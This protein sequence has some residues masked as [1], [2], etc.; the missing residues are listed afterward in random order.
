MKELPLLKI[1]A[2]LED[3]LW[4]DPWVEQAKKTVNSVICFPWLRDVLHGVPLGHPF[5]PVAVQI[6]LGAW[7][8]A[9]VLDAVPGQERAAG[10]LV[11]VG[12]LTVVPAAVSGWTDWSDLHEQQQ[13]VGLVH[14]A[15][16]IAATGLYVASL[17]ERSRGRQG[18]GKLL[19]Y[20]GFA[21]LG[22]AGF[23]GGH[24]S[25]RQAAGV[26]HSE[27]VPHRF[28]AGWHSLARL[29][30]LADGELEQR[31][32]AGMPLLVLRAGEE[33][34]V[35]SDV[36]S[37]LSGPLHEGTIEH[38]GEAC[39]ICPWH[40]SVFSL[41]SGEVLGGP[42]TAPQPRYETR[43]VDGLVEVSLPGAG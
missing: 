9:A 8:S 18:R 41:R 19:G 32:V 22:A 30:E 36:C 3:G 26:N 38:R 43:V 28:P 7:T 37:H 27:D 25:Y 6:P 20:L 16:N 1:V 10:I 34:Q 31:T 14:A 24:L 39:V 42:A 15:A 33:V 40:G 17:V 2:R 29:T 13:R 5:H 23:L 4:L 11:G 35:L 12:A 21:T